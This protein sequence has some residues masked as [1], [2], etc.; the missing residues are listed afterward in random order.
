MV[1][2]AG[3][4]PKHRSLIRHTFIQTRGI[5]LEV[6]ERGYLCSERAQSV[7][8]GKVGQGNACFQSH[9]LGIPLK[10]KGALSFNF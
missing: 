2:D 1:I 6:Y 4:E 5:M 10:G 9:I 7:G 8:S 3:Q